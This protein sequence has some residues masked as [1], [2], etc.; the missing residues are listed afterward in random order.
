MTPPCVMNID[1]APHTPAEATR[2][3]D[4]QSVDDQETTLDADDPT[5]EE[6]G[7]GY[8]V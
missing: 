8:G 5:P 7:Y 4:G 6:A 3:L 1:P 2:R